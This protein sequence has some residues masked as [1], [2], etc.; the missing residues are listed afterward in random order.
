MGSAWDNSVYPPVI[1][2]IYWA[3]LLNKETSLFQVKVRSNI[4]N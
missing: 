4:K 2:A 3:Y 1:Q